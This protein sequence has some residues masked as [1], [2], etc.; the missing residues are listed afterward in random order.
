VMLTCMCMS[1][2][3]LNTSLELRTVDLAY[4][5]AYRALAQ[6]PVR[7]IYTH[8]PFVWENADHPGMN[9]GSLSW[10]ED[11]W[12]VRSIRQYQDKSFQPER[13]SLLLWDEYRDYSLPL[14]NLKGIGRPTM[15]FP[16]C[17]WH[18]SLLRAFPDRKWRNAI[19]VQEID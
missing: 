18:P 4:D 13:P 11:G 12:Q 3:M 6:Q 7:T 2:N 8:W 17:I 19:T 1:L 16:V 15:N 10:H 14:D 5:R 9:N